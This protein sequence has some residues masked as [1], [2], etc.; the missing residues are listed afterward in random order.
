MKMPLRNA[1]LKLVALALALITW[2]AVRGQTIEQSD[3]LECPVSLVLPADVIVQDEKALSLEIR[4]QGPLDTLADFRPTSMTLRVDARETVED[5]LAS[6]ASATV[7]VEIARRHFRLPRAL[8]L[9]EYDPKTISFQVERIEE[10]VLP[11]EVTSFGTPADGYR[12]VAARA[13]PSTVTLALGAEEAKQITAVP[14]TPVDVTGC[15]STVEDKAHLIDPRGEGSARLGETVDVI[16]T[17]EP[18]LA[19]KPLSAVP[20]MVLQRPA[21]RRKVA[22][23]PEAVTVTV[24]GRADLIASLGPEAVAAYLVIDEALDPGVYTLPLVVVS[25]KP[26][27]EVVR[28]PTVQVTIE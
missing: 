10:T 25:K 4:V 17:I 5:A 14:T 11:V 15:T 2:F 16:V 1:K 28:A 6:Q 26:G 27:I 24:S 18:V 9:A 7:S 21:A 23:D 20:I 13:L 8:D 3:W 19:Q 22:V 12:I